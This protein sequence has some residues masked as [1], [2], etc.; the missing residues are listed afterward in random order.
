M[1]IWN[2]S[3]P[4]NWIIHEHGIKQRREWYCNQIS[5]PGTDCWTKCLK[6]FSFPVIQSPSYSSDVW[7]TEMNR[8]QEVTPHPHKYICINIQRDGWSYQMKKITK[9]LDCK[10]LF[11]SLAY[12]NKWNCKL[13]PF[14]EHW[15]WIIT[16]LVMTLIYASFC[17]SP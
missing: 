14:M 6:T 4:V 11:Y 2:L 8:C 13:Y 3:V 10:A 17:P 7:I 15:R 16:L 9:Y 5:K 12:Q 1:G